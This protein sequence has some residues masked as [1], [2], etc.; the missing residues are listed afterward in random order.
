MSRRALGRGLDALFQPANSLGNELIDLDV[1]SIDPGVEQPRRDFNEEK[2][3][4][5]A[6]SIEANGVIQPIVVR[7]VGE[8]FQ[9]IAGERRW[10]AAKK[11]GLKRIPSLVRDVADANVLELSLIENI[12]RQ[13]LNP[14]EE[15]NAYRR[16]QTQLGITQEAVAQ[17]VG[18]DRS[19]VTNSL[20]LLRLPEEVQRLV[21][22]S[23]LSMGH[24]RALLSIESPERQEQLASEMVTKLLSVREAERLVKNELTTGGSH[25]A[26]MP[27][28]EARHDGET[29]NVLAAEQ[30]LSRKLGA[31]VKIKFSGVGG[32]IEIRFSSGEEL[33]RIFELLVQR[34]PG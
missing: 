11:T 8:R 3:T 24:A 6:R 1:D 30:R 10:R 12:Q 16:L 20:R 25:P 27:K 17:R 13:E 14:I 28:N 19:T 9:I 34:Q 33:S 4:E 23:R 7:R 5:L 18:K 15:A 26:R 22:D 2:L 29:A 21:E 32:A 31:Q